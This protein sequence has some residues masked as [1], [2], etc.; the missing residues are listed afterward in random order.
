MK[1]QSTFTERLARIETGT[2]FG[3]AEPYTAAD[4]MQD[5][6]KQRRLH[7]DM[8]AAGGFLGGIAGVLFA[9]QFGLLVLMSFDMVTLY[10]MLLADYVKLALLVGVMAAPIGFL[11]GQVFAHDTPRLRYFWVGYGAGVVAANWSDIQIYYAT[12]ITAA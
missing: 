6:K 5:D 3:G 10:Q 9:H 8:L 2:T 11:L 4:L 7:L 1:V 12:L